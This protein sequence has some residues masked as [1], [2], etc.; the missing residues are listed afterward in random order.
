MCIK[1]FCFLTY[2]E[3]T[4]SP[5]FVHR[6]SCHGGCSFSVKWCV[7]LYRNSLVFLL[8]L[9]VR[10]HT[11]VCIVVPEH[12]GVYCS[13]MYRS[14][15]VCELSYRNT[16]GLL[17]YRNILMC[18]V[19]QCTGAHRCVNY[20]TGTH[21]WVIVLPEHIMCVLYRDTPVCILYRNTPVYRTGTHQCIVPEHRV[22]CTGTLVCVLYR[23]TP[24]CCTGTPRFVYCTE[25]HRY[26]YCSAMYRNTPVH[27]LYW[28]TAVCELLY[29]STPE[30]VLFIIVQENSGFSSPP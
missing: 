2:Q 5:Y 27:V 8:L 11:S 22:Y 28:N 1:S 18:I 9:N 14:T 21:R 4:W 20:C 12:T 19:P 30:C 23:N 25:T 15:P 16:G 6:K 26:A 17:F 3:F 29:W 7:L 13:A 24:V 10:E